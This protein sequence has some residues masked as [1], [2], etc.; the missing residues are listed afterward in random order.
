M[1]LYYYKGTP[2]YFMTSNTTGR[3]LVSGLEASKIPSVRR[4]Q[5]LPI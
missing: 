4:H 1:F 5:Q 2:E 3:I